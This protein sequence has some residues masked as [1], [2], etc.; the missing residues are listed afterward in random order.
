[1]ED[2]K[3][4][5]LPASRDLTLLQICAAG[6]PPPETL[7]ERVCV[8]QD[9]VTARLDAEPE[10]LSPTPRLDLCCTYFLIVFVLWLLFEVAPVFLSGRVNEVIRQQ[11]NIHRCGQ[12]GDPV[13]QEE[14]IVATEGEGH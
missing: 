11:Q 6:S 8:V 12:I 14:C 2:R 3:N 9:R 13:A 5:G 10:P 1:M 7:Y 4:T